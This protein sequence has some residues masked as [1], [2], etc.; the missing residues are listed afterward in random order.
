MMAT[1]YII[2]AMSRINQHML[3]TDLTS[4]HIVVST[5]GCVSL[6]STAFC[7]ISVCELRI[8]S[9]HPAVYCGHHLD[10]EGWQAMSPLS[11][12]LA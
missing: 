6:I 10:T 11:H 9:L 2:L 7:L 1:F 5:S 4:M 12:L 3:L 8:V